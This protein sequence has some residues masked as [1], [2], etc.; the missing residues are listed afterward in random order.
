MQMKKKI[1][2][3][4]PVMAQPSEIGLFASSLAFMQPYANMEFLDPLSIIDMDLPNEAYYE[5][6]QSHL[7]SIIPH[8]DA[9]I[10][11]SFGGVILQQ[12]FSLFE[13][14]PI[15]LFSTPTFSDSALHQKLGMVIRLCEKK[16]L[17]QALNTLYAQVYYPNP[18]PS[19]DWT[20]LDP[21]EAAKRL[22]TGLTRVLTTDSSYLVKTS[23]INLL[24]LMGEHSDLVN[25]QNVLPPKKGL[26]LTVPG[27]GMRVLQD[28][29]AFCRNPILEKLTCYAA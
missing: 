27:A 3:I 29:L 8:F 10:G 5:A 7:A 12:C 28:N 20:T 4:A 15:I 16:Q 11:F 2:I 26:L 22:K 23:N 18:Q 13:N 6:W 9:F 25:A 14:Q 1:L 19:C 21:S 24:H 17:E